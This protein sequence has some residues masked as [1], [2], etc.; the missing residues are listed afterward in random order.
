MSCARKV[1][2]FPTSPWH[3]MSGFNAL[4]KRLYIFLNTVSISDLMINLQYKQ[5][6]TKWRKRYGSV[7][8]QQFV[9]SNVNTSEHCL[10]HLSFPIPR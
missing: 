10:A 2:L 8:D 1:P 6:F 7:Q 5:F 9:L 4:F 3:T